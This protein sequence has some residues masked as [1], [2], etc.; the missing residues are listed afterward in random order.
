[1]RHLLGVGVGAFPGISLRG[2]LL[3]S[4]TVLCVGWSP[5]AKASVRSSAAEATAVLLVGDAIKERVRCGGI[6]SGFMMTS[7]SSSSSSSSYWMSSSAEDHV[8]RKPPSVG[9]GPSGS[10]GGTGVGDGLLLVQ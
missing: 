8:N 2:F 9:G 10:R 3:G 4:A 7:S 6:F 1:M 5:N